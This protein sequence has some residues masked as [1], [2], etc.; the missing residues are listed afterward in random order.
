[1]DSQGCNDFYLAYGVGALLTYYMISA[2]CSR[3]DSFK[4]MVVAVLASLF[5]PIT[6]TWGMYFTF[7]GKE[8]Y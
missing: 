2:L 8:E 3:V 7:K 6:F 5:W 4:S 1:M